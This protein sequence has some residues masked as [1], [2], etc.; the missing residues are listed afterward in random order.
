MTS[1]GV[2]LENDQL[3]PIWRFFL[4]VV[5][6]FA[7]IIL[8]SWIVGT[9]YL[10]AN[11][12]HGMAANLFWQSLVCLIVVMAAFKAMMS[13]FDRRPLGSMGL[14][15]FDG[16][17]RQLV[18]GIVVGG[19]M[20]LLAVLLEM[21]AGGVRFSVI[22]HPALASSGLFSLFLFAI[23]AAK[24]EVI[25]RG[26]AFQRLA[27][28]ITPAGAIAV[29]SAFFGLAHLANP[30]RTWIST[31]NTMLVAIPFCIAYLR[32]RSLWMP[33]GMHFIWNLLQG[34]FLG[35]PVS[36]M[37]LSTSVLTPRVE[38]AIWLTGGAYGPEGSLFATVAIF[39][40]IIYLSRMKSIYTTEEMKVLVLAPAAGPRNEPPI[41]I[42]SALPRE[43]VKRD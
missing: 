18:V 36:G 33:I 5:V 12:Q 37:V 38:G 23:A 41:S 9:A 28:S 26:Y 3:L 22:P 27:E 29:S 21:S 7:S 4:A 11:V 16:W 15:F 25:F 17:Q 14:T 20:L 42:F 8:T 30:H 35:L 6:I 31:F 24:E 1:H 32:T 40:G 19:A 2:F 39:A 13:M 34:F 10:I 43:E